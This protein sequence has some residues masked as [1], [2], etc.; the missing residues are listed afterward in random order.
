MRQTSI[1]ATCATIHHPLECCSPRNRKSVRR[2]CIGCRVL[3]DKKGTC[4]LFRK[5]LRIWAWDCAR[6]TFGLSLSLSLF[7]GLRV[8]GT[9]FDLLCMDALTGRVWGMC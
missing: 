4:L 5:V 8:W 7:L 2:V 1:R 6:L 9:G 3:C